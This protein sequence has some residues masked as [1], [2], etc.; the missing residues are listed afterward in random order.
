MYRL[1]FDPQVQDAQAAM[2]I[3]TM[4]RREWDRIYARKQK[5][6]VRGNSKGKRVTRKER[7][8]K[9]DKPDMEEDS[10]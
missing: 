3:Y 6:S 5:R 4:H 7:L 1:K 10:D 9:E 2:R 8:A